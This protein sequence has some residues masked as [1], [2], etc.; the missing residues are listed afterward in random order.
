MGQGR[1]IIEYISCFKVARDKVIDTVNEFLAAEHKHKQKLVAQETAA[2]QMQYVQKV[3]PDPKH[4][5]TLMQHAQQCT[6]PKMD[7][8]VF[9]FSDSKTEASP[10]KEEAETSY[11]PS[12]AAADSAEVQGVEPLKPED[13]VPPHIAA[14]PT[15]PSPPGQPAPNIALNFLLF[16]SCRP[17]KS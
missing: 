6:I 11:Q 5:A 9:D 13:A 17:K 1:S 3:M 15:P 7:P 16:P 2:E 8:T 10:G 12:A 14:L 4:F